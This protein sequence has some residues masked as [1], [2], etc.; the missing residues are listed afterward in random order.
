LDN[1]PLAHGHNDDNSGDEAFNEDDN[2][3]LT[4][5]GSACQ[6]NGKDTN[7]DN[8]DSSA[9]INGDD[10]DVVQSLGLCLHQP[11]QPLLMATMKSMMVMMMMKH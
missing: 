11:L 1:H 2:D 10:D 6:P 5:S 3:A 7:D 8:K 4:L 9:T